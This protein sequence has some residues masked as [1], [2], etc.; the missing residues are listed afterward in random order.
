MVLIFG[1]LVCF[2]GTSCCDKKCLSDATNLPGRI[3]KHLSV[4][5]LQCETGSNLALLD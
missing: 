4:F 5:G 3:W 1:L 2:V